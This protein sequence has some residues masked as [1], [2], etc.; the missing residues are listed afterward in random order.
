MFGGI[1]ALLTMGFIL[2]SQVNIALL[3]HFTSHRIFSVA[4]T[5]QVCAGLIF[6]VGVQQQWW[7]LRP[8]WFCSL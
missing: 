3:K 2:G 6:Y 7:E 4:L 8:I 5:T 1:F